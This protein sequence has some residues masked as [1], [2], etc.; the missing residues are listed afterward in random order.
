MTSGD[1]D[2][3]YVDFVLDRIQKQHQLGK[4]KRMAGAIYKALV[5]K[6]LLDEYHTLIKARASHKRAP[7]VPLPLT[8]AV[9]YRMNEVRAMYENPGPY[10]KRSARAATFEEHLEH[11]YFSQGFICTQREG[12]EWVVKTAKE[13]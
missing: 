1:Y 3:G 13:V 4:V 11:V 8:P 2:L 5:E 9:A 6:Y 12:E 10:A 7:V